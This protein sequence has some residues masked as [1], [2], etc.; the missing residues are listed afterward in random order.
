MLFDET[1]L[2]Y[3]FFYIKNYYLRMSLHTGNLYQIV[4][5]NGRNCPTER[6]RENCPNLPI[7]CT[8]SAFWDKE[9]A[10]TENFN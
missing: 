8:E 4:S 2:I 5:D 10:E 6:P 9:W 7:S 3:A 1:A